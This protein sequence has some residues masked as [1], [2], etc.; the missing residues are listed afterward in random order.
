MCKLNRGF[1]HPSC[2]RSDGWSYMTMI[3]WKN[4]NYWTAGGCNNTTGSIVNIYSRTADERTT[5]FAPVSILSCIRAITVERSLTEDEIICKRTLSNPL[6]TS[7]IVQQRF[8]ETLQPTFGIHLKARHVGKCPRWIPI[9]CQA[10]AA[11]FLVCGTGRKLDDTHDHCHRRGVHGTSPG[12]LT[13]NT[14][15]NDS[16]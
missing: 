13:S 16:E 2:A 14:T 4:Y 1:S 15:W 7:F 12:C 8:H 10:E 9:A 6:I 3:D 5:L 11:H